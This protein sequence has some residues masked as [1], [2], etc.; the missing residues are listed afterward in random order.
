MILLAA[1]HSSSISPVIYSG[2]VSAVISAVVA[3]LGNALMAYIQSKNNQETI[4]T[5][6]ENARMDRQTNLLYKSRVD[7]FDSLRSTIADLIVNFENANSILEDIQQEKKE[8]ANNSMQ[9][10][11]AAIAQ[12]A[13]KL[14]DLQKKSDKTFAE[15]N[16]EVSL[17]R[18]YLYE[19]TDEN[20][21]MLSDL[22]TMIASLDKNKK[23]TPER[24]D[25]FVEKSRRYL[26]KQMEQ[27]SEKVK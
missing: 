6:K 15:L 24:L 11:T 17:V 25:A 21:K 14:T 19:D 23:V 7:Q 16:K 3:I 20:E 18:L 22:Q 9:A 2:L 10:T 8:L 13:V 12:H 26:A 27:L 5:Q 4:K 1:S